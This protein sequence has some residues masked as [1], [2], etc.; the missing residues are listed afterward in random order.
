MGT[1]SSKIKNYGKPLHQYWVKRL[2]HEPK[3]LMGKN[4]Y[5]RNKTQIVLLLKYA[6]GSKGKA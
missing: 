5:L 3:M 1:Q 2:P 6:G 4:V